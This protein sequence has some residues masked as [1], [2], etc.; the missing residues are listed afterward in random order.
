MYQLI[1][2]SLLRMFFLFFFWRKSIIYHQ[3]RLKL[4]CNNGCLLV[5]DE[6]YYSI[7]ITLLVYLSPFAQFSCRYCVFVQSSLSTIIAHLSIVVAGRIY[8]SYG[9]YLPSLYIVSLYET[10]GFSHWNSQ[11]LSLKLPVPPFE[12]PGISQ[13]A[14]SPIVMGKAE[15]Y[16][17]IARK[18]DR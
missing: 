9:T 5:I 2:L 14:V 8:R 16:S 11:F 15:F 13:C 17:R 12:T 7:S 4:L 10:L 6:K 3:K 18:G 1:F